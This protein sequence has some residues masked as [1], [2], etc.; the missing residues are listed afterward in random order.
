MGTLD[1]K[2]LLSRTDFFVFP[3]VDETILCFTLEASDDDITAVNLVQTDKLGE[4]FCSIPLSQIDRLI[5]DYVATIQN[6]FNFNVRIAKRVELR[7]ESLMGLWRAVGHNNREGQHS[8][9][10][11]RHVG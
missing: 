3:G 7:S 9:D 6:Y 2:L 10:R 5:C 8:F 4:P 11:V 1:D